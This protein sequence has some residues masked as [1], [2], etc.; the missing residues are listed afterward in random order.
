MNMRLLHRIAF[1]LV[2]PL[3]EKNPLKS[4]AVDA[5]LVFSMTRLVWLAFAAGMLRQMAVSGIAGWPEATLAIAI[6]VAPALLGALQQV[7]PHDVLAFGQMLVGRFGIGEVGRTPSITSLTPIEPIR[8]DDHR[9][10]GKH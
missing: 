7:D 4:L 1:A 5:P 3:L 10:D 2:T 8:V 9:L 6:V